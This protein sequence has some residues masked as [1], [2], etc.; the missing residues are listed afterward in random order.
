MFQ[1]LFVDVIQFQAIYRCAKR[2]ANRMWWQTVLREKRRERCW[3]HRCLWVVQTARVAIHTLTVISDKGSWLVSSAEQTRLTVRIAKKSAE[4]AHT[5]L[6]ISEWGAEQSMSS[7]E[8]SSKCNIQL[9][10]AP[11]EA[12]SSWRNICQYDKCRVGSW[13]IHA[14]ARSAEQ[15]NSVVRTAK[16]SAYHKD[17]HW[18][19]R[20][21][22]KCDCDKYIENTWLLAK[23]TYMT[24]I[25]VENPFKIMSTSAWNQMRIENLAFSIFQHKTLSIFIGRTLGEIWCC[26]MQLQLSN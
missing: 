15:A 25:T 12:Q 5:I 14:I 22:S 9:W 4:H 17:G 19:R 2:R 13:L 7:A 1:L 10:V 18:E 20:Q 11:R 16:K 6:G 21:L 26:A 23:L 8:T 24:H 3:S